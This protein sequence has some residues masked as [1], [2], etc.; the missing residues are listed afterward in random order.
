LLILAAGALL[1]FL[2]LPITPAFTR[3]LHTG[4]KFTPSI[5]AIALAMYNLYCIFVS[6]SVAPWFW[7]PGIL[8]SLA[9]ACVMLLVL[10][11]SPRPARRFLI[12]FIILLAFMTFFQVVNAKRLIVIGPWL[13]LPT[14]VTIAGTTASVVRRW[15]LFSL[16]LIGAIGWYGIFSRNLYA[17][18]RWIEP[19][20]RVSRIAAEVSDRGGSSSE[21]TIP[22][23][24]I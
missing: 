19:W 6:E 3:E 2:S 12:F 16:V 20:D 15:I 5:S 13:I 9:I 4:A 24:S 10:I 1:V 14:A 21:T 7:V 17:A 18:P 11:Y 8:A 22:S 23:F